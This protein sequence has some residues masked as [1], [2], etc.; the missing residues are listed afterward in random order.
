ME[1]SSIGDMF[2]H[3]LKQAW[4]DQ[5]LTDLKGKPLDSIQCDIEPG[6]SME[7]IYT[8]KETAE[9]PSIHW[10][11]PNASWKIVE[12]FKPGTDDD[13][14]KLNSGILE[15]LQGGCELL[16]IDTR[17]SQNIVLDQLLRD[18]NLEMITLRID[19]GVPSDRKISLDNYLEDHA[20][21][22]SPNDTGVSIEIIGQTLF[23]YDLNEKDSSHTQELA[24]LLSRLTSFFSSKPDMSWKHIV[25]EFNVG[26]HNLIELSKIRALKLLIYALAEEIG[27]PLDV[28]PVLRANVISDIIQ[29]ELEVVIERGAK[30]FVAVLAGVDEL[31]IDW[32]FNTNMAITEN[33]KRRVMR[34]IHWL[35]KLESQ[36][37]DHTDI[38]HGSYW[39][40]QCTKLLFE[41]AWSLYKTGGEG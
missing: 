32:P 13:A 33:D 37:A 20:N 27:K 39:I 11:M 1:K 41:K 22:L 14:Q 19:P 30:A 36:L 18:V 10:G 8:R 5:V 35:L 6:L 16:E 3:Q 4:R 23:R 21:K 15:C 2:D 38:A 26:N 7:P 28:F 29:D 17:Q 9:L 12:Q 25:I 24:H 31:F 34:N 40:E